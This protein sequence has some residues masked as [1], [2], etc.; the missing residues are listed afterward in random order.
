MYSTPLYE[1]V[2]VGVVAGVNQAENEDA[3]YGQGLAGY[4]KRYASGFADQAIG[5]F[6]TGAIFP[7]ILRE[8]PRYF[9]S[10]KGR[11]PRRFTYALSR[12][13]LIRT[14]SGAG[15]VQFN[16]SEFLGTGAAAG[17][18]NLYE[19][20]QDRTLSNTA[21]TWAEQISIDGLGLD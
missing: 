7:T 5:N 3:A 14:D 1:F 19:V 20:P 17:I 21:T 11:F 9:R 13:L 2:I 6:M 15:N 4:A 8:D 12:L 16:F 10:G 18:S